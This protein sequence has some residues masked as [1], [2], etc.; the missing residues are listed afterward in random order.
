LN[1]EAVYSEVEAQYGK[2][3]TVEEKIWITYVEESIGKLEEEFGLVIPVADRISALADRYLRR[4]YRDLT[5]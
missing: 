5:D 1:Y 2:A 3:G 4:L